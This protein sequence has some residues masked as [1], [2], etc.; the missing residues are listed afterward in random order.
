[1]NLLNKLFD[2]VYGDIEN[3]NENLIEAVKGFDDKSIIKAFCSVT[4]GEFVSHKSFPNCKILNKFPNIVLRTVH[5]K[6]TIEYPYIFS[7]NLLHSL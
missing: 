7:K 4:G 3:L 1:M 5:G 6:R 2:A